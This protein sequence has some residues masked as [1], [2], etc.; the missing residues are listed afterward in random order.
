MKAIEKAV[1]KVAKGITIKAEYGW[2]PI[3]SGAFYQPERPVVE[4]SVELDGKESDSAAE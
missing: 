1:S 2:P 4:P 3:C